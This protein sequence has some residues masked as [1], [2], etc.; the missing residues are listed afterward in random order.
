MKIKVTDNLRSE[1]FNVG[2][3]FDAI[4]S[5]NGCVEFFDKN[6]MRWTLVPHQ[7]VTIEE[8]PSFTSTVTKEEF[9]LTMSRLPKTL[10]IDF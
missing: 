1:S 7:Y 5:G 8:E 9:C 6:G 2:D 10:Q 3:V 4:S